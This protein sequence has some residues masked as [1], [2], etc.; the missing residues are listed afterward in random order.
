MKMLELVCKRVEELKEQ[1]VCVAELVFRD[2]FTKEYIF[3]T[4][5]FDEGDRC[6]VSLYNS[7]YIDF[8]LKGGKE[9]VEI[10]FDAHLFANYT[11]ETTIEAQRQK[12]LSIVSD[13]CMKATIKR[14]S[15]KYLAK[16]SNETEK[17]RGDIEYKIIS[18]KKLEK[19][20]AWE[21]AV[22]TVW[23]IE[24]Y[25]PK[26]N[27]TVF[28]MYNDIQGD[29]Y[30]CAEKS[31]M[32]DAESIATAFAY[33]RAFTEDKIPNCVKKDAI[34]FKREE[35]G[36][37]NDTVKSEYYDLFYELEQYKDEDVRKNIK[38]L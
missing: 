34:S 25:L 37:F 15:E 20:T 38:L 33:K 5:L 21:H 26:E 13:E 3:Y 6:E 16:K 4:V 18:M 27:K 32:E 30:A 11:G 29:Y 35:Y 28:V 7:S 24:F 22:D 9:P 2:K 36:S 1:D 23:E 14:C 8:A 19:R 17:P 12:L 31:M 10:E